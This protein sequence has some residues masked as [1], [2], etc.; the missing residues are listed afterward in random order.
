MKKCE[1]CG[2]YLEID[3]NAG[4]NKND[5]Y[6]IEHVYL[7]KPPKIGSLW[8][9]QVKMFHCNNNKDSTFTV[10]IEHE[11]GR[12]VSYQGTLDSAQNTFSPTYKYTVGKGIDEQ[13]RKLVE[14]I[15]NVIDQQQEFSFV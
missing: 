9:V 6:P 1:K 7:M 13:Q 3:M 15:R 11:D 5:K 14:K 4:G 12:I 2:T 10:Q 8:E